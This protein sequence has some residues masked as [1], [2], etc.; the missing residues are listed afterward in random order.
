MRPHAEPVNRSFDREV[1]QNKQAAEQSAAGI[2]LK[3]L[4][5]LTF[6]RASH[7]S[8]G[9]SADLAFLGVWEKAAYDEH[10]EVVRGRASIVDGDRP[11]SALWAPLM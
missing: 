7:R 11:V 1:C 10:L 6:G 3:A 9:E 8:Q 2:A 5:E 4:E